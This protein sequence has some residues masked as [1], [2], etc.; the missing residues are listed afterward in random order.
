MSAQPNHHSDSKPILAIDLDDVLAPLIQDFCDYLNHKYG[1]NIQIGPG[2]SYF[3]VEKLIGISA[4]ELV[5]RLEEYFE[6]DIYHRV[7]PFEGAID[8]LSDLSRKYDLILITARPD[9]VRNVS[10]RW[11]ESH[12]PETFK[13]THFVG[14]SK[15]SPTKLSVMDRYDAVGLIDDN[16]HNIEDV[17]AAGKK[18]IL[19]GDYHWN[20]IHKLPAGV[21]RARDWEEVLEKL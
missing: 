9:T 4:E 2:F 19:F 6:S 17:A 10:E 3:G 1:T 16:L 5:V 21:V 14:L 12:F 7:E 13:H 8:A 20:Q 11:L 18:A 15:D